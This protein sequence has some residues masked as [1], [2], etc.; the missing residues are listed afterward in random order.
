[1]RGCFRVAIQTIGSAAPTGYEF[2]MMA[3]DE[4]SNTTLSMKM[5]VLSFL[6]PESLAIQPRQ[7]NQKQAMGSN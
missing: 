6:F 7:S 2:V 3:V 5:T 4:D 1:M